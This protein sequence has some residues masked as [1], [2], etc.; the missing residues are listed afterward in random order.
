MSN[1][2]NLTVENFKA[3]S[4]QW[5]EIA[6]MNVRRK[7]Q[8]VLPSFQDL[9][10]SAPLPPGFIVSLQSLVAESMRLLVHYYDTRDA[11]ASQDPLYIAAGAWSSPFEGRFSAPYNVHA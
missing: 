3:Y 7:L 6:R 5:A 2:P 8:E 10:H 9:N 1:L 11:I 4:E